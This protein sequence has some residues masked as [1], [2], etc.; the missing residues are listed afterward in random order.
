MREQTVGE[1]LS[2]NGVSRRT[3]IKFCVS[4][5]SFLALAPGMGQVIAKQ[6][7]KT[8][9]PSVIYLSF[10]ECTGCLESLT[11]SYT[12]S[13]ENMIFNMISLDYDDT[14]MAAAGKQSEEARDAAIKENYGK[15]L[16]VVDGAVP[17]GNGGVYNTQG[18][19]S[20]VQILRDTAKGAAAIVCVGTCSSY[21]GLPYANPNP[22][23]AVPVSDIITDK[24]LINVPGCPPIP[25]VIT[26]TLVQYVTLGVP[27]LDAHHR[28]LA[29][30]GNT[31]HDRC[32]RRPYFDVGKFA[33]TFDDEGARNGWC[34]YELG[35]KGPTTYNACATVKWNEG[36]S[37]PIE[38]G[39]PCL[40]CS[41]PSFW[42]RN[43]SFYAPLA[44]GLIG[45]LAPA[46]EAA[47]V[48]AA[49]GIGAAA[50]SRLRSRAR[51]QSRAAE[52]TASKED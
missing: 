37:F 16:V 6:L 50:L 32:Y 52:K 19:K 29:F 1:V 20:A 14:L 31:I 38:S 36:T 15:Y 46:G 9:R 28:P 47:G 8:K 18:G 24:P 22:T 5:A 12:P 2:A 51:T 21:G 43:G 44:A 25:A 30:Y 48:G 27:A 35:C 11:R 42:D 40:G 33:K 7:L 17:L 10:Q 49:V 39:H 23:G 45:S 3:F 41:E 34:L 13:V 26:S 4:T